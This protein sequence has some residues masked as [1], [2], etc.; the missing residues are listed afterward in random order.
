MT[1][2]TPILFYNPGSGTTTIGGT[3]LPG[4][5]YYWPTIK[6]LTGGVPATDLDAQSIYLLPND[7][8]IEV[9]I[10]DRGASQWLRVQNTSLPAPPAGS[11][12]SGNTDLDAG[13][14]VPLS[15]DPVSKPW[16][17]HR[18]LGY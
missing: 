4:Y 17:L 16:I 15:Y 13:V 11:I 7:S 9:V 2:D 6:N 1:S 12:V 5:L 18:Q 8:L 14:I 10:P 3:V